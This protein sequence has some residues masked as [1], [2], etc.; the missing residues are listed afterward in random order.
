MLGPRLRLGSRFCRGVLVVALA[1]AT[2]LSAAPI[3]AQV[4]PAGARGGRSARGAH[5][6]VTVVVRGCRACTVQAVRYVPAEGQDPWWSRVRKVGADGQVVFTVPTRRTRGMTFF[7]D[8]PW[9]G[10]D[11]VASVMV[12]RYAGLTTGE[13]VTPPQARS[14]RRGEACWAGTAGPSARIVMRVERYRSRTMS[15]GKPTW[16]PR[17]WAVRGLESMPPM[18]RT[19][20]GSIGA[21]DAIGCGPSPTAP[22]TLT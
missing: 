18:V 21:Q 14:A 16:H 1:G 8:A 10:L 13:R 6:T 2:V 22:K 7:V 19:F 20:K 5:T 9:H 12:A 15:Q 3:S 11:G 17:A 4:G